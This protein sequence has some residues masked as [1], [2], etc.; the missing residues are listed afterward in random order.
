[1]SVALE[2]IVVPASVAHTATVI[3][4]H[5]LGDT[6]SG[7]K[8][9]ADA[10]KNDAQL[11]HVKWVLPHSPTMRVTANNGVEMPSWF[12]ILAFGFTE[13]EDEKGMLKSSALIKEL[14][15]AEI[16]AGIPADR[17]VLGGFSQGGSMS[18][19]TGLSYDK[20]LAGLVV[21]SGWLPLQ[22]R[23]KQLATPGLAE[24]LPVFM[25]HG[26]T[27]PLVKIEMNTATVDYLTKELNMPK[28]TSSEGKPTGLELHVYENMWHVASPQELEDLKSWLIRAIPPQN[29]EK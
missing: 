27:D 12:N 9:V 23:L 13:A 8:P 19:L 1:M 28:A 7:W 21:L 15:D 16:S 22:H 3:F 4:V 24:R 2:R 26:S 18:L 17:I 20:T 25:G 11:R 5:G 29:N 14:L 6:G 10:F